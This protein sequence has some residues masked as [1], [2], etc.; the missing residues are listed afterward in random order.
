MGDGA[1][2]ERE[3]RETDL[4]LGRVMHAVA[5]R[6]VAGVVAKRAVAQGL[7]PMGRRQNVWSALLLTAQAVVSMEKKE[8]LQRHRVENDSHKNRSSRKNASQKKQYLEKSQRRE[9]PLSFLRTSSNL[10]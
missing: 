9:P 1:E 5:Q 3:I 6:A 4:R 10:E 7:V 8:E 2:R